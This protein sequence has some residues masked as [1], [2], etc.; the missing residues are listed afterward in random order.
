MAIHVKDF[1]VGPH[2]PVRLKDWPTRSKPICSSKKAYQKL[3][4]HHVE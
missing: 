2:H 1:R 4:K 3:L